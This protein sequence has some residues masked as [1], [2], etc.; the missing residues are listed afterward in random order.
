MRKVRESSMLRVRTGAVCALMLAFASGFVVPT[1]SGADVTVVLDEAKL[2]KLPDRVATIV[3]GNPLIADAS[4]QSGGM[5]VLT[6]KGYGMTNLIAL[7]RA[8][9]VLMERSVEVKGPAG[10]VVVV[11]RGIERESYSCTPECE[12]RITLGDGNAY[13]ESVLG[14]TGIRNAQAQGGT[15]PSK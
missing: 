9:S 1:A 8:G 7:D 13:F 3:I 5:M 4:I 15:V 14:Q 2:I 11:Y 6:G 10:H 12:K